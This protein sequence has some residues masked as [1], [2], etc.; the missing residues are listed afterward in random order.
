M[1]PIPLSVYEGT[2]IN[3]NLN[4]VNILKDGP[5]KLYEVVN[6]SALDQIV[7]DQ[8]TEGLN[9][10]LVEG[11]V[12]TVKRKAEW[13]RSLNVTYQDVNV[14]AVKYYEIKTDE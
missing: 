7:T 1:E 9:A 5:L 14:F 13:P 12:H 2:L 3:S 11:P 8:M 10:F 6:S 4:P